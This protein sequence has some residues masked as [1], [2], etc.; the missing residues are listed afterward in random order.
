MADFVFKLPDIGEGTAEAEIVAWHVKPGDQVTED[1][2]LVDVMTDKA[3]VEM[4]SPVCGVI[5]AIHGRVNEK[6]AVGSPLVEFRLD[7]GASHKDE[8][9]DPKSGEVES[10][11]VVASVTHADAA[12][13]LEASRSGVTELPRTPPPKQT[14]ASPAVRRR[15]YEQGVAL[16]FI[17]GTGP[18]GRVT[19]QDL[20][21]FFSGTARTSP[22]CLAMHGRKRGKAADVIEE[23]KIVGL[24]RKDRKSVV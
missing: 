24:R 2:R 14:L 16:Q 3:I 12:K 19:H 18:A 4:T 5:A 1:R 13:S 21:D 23:V 7:Q 9:S 15:A 17:Q 22:S 8:S 20:E 11:R 6:V 10:E